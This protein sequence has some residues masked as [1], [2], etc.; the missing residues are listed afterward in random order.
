L[1]EPLLIDE[2]MEKS[3][4]NQPYAPKWK[5]APKYGAR[6]GKKMYNSFS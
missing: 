3:L 5:Q 2:T 6:G 1:Y 4:R